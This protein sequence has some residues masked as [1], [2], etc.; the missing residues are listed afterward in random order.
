MFKNKLKLIFKHKIISGVVAAIIIIGGY[1]GYQALIGT[2]QETRYV[3]AAATKET[4]ITTVSGT[5]QVSVSNQVD[6][7]AKAS[8]EAYNVNVSN[9]QLVKS[10]DI[11]VQLNAQDA[12]KSVRD[13]EANLE[14]AKISMEKLTQ[15]TDSLSLLQAQNTLAQAQEAKT[16]A[17][18]DLNQA[19]EDSSNAI[20]DA[21]LDLPTIITELYTIR[22]SSEIGTSEPTIGRSQDNASALYNTLNSSDREKLFPFQ[23][24]VE[25]DYGIARAKYDINFQ[26][27]KD[28]SRYSDR[29]TIENLLNET[30][31][32]TKAIAQ[33]AKSENNYL[34][35]WSDY[36]SKVGGNIFS[37]VTTYQNTLNTDIGNT[38]THLSKL[39]SLQATLQ[40]SQQAITNAERTIAEKTESLAKLQA[41]TDALDLQSQQLAIRQ[42][43]NA[44]ADA[45][46]KLADYTVR[47]PF[48]GLIAS[49]AVKK[50][51]SISS[52]ATVATL[53]TQQKI[54]NVSLNE[55]DIAK[56]KIGQKATLSFDAISDLEITGTVIDI[57]TIGTVSQGVVSYNIKIGLDAQDD[58]IKPGM[59]ASANIITDS[60]VDVLTV[61]S[62]AVKNQGNNYYVQV[63]KNASAADLA[64]SQGVVPSSALETKTVTVGLSDDTNTEI[65]SG[66]TEGEAVLTK[67]LTVKASSQQSSAPSLL[68]S[69]TPNRNNKTTNTSNSTKSS[70]GS[71]DMPMIPPN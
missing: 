10:G 15:P 33:A 6:I 17:E 54:V 42:R 29:Q 65:L 48:D 40:S 16:Q 66:L 11:L 39:L 68:Q 69:L 46:E 56:V 19:Y 27:Y 67:T 14:S 35:A 45:R 47:A 2:K 26:H 24:N 62:S 23:T 60:R 7:K 20:S 50:A 63:Y 9:G 49:V 53:I 18:D 44:L 21:F 12:L 37:K 30:L 57:D 58:R 41:G 4:I 25:T 59:S 8:G 70:S 3:L 31:D 13:A 28:T 61:P 5:G 38:N 43:E 1:F 34:D 22:Y 52:G 51:D 55:V 32:A 64:N 36:R 71:N